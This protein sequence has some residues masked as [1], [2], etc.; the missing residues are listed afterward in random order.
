MA[1]IRAWSGCATSA[2][3]VSTIPDQQNIFQSRMSHVLSRKMFGKCQTNIVCN[4]LSCAVLCVCSCNLLV[5]VFTQHEY[6]YSIHIGLYAELQNYTIC[7]EW[8]IINCLWGQQTTFNNHTDISHY[9]KGINYNL[10][11]ITC[12]CSTWTLPSYHMPGQYNNHGLH[13]MAVPG[14]CTSNCHS[15]KQHT[16]KVATSASLL[17]MPS[18][19]WSQPKFTRADSDTY[20][21]AFGTCVDVVHL[22]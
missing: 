20:Q 11:T 15:T 17:N 2:K 19:D 12:S 13:C 5:S 10:K 14:H 22:Q 16:S 3:T 1:T 4:I 6:W 21:Q 18:V 7:K 9:I 8:P